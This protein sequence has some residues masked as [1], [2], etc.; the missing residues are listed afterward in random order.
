MSF[1]VVKVSCSND[2][3]DIFMAEMA[4]AG[5]DSFSDNDQ[6]FEA[7]IES[8]SFDEE[9]VKEIF[10]R[11]HT[12][13]TATY[14]V[15][16]VGKKNW[17]EEWEKNY[18]P[19]FIDDRCVVKASFHQIEKKFPYEITINP[20]MSFGTGHHETT[21]LMLSH[22]LEL[23]HEE[24]TVL[25]AGCGTGILA[26]MASKLGAMHVLA[27]DIDDWCVENSSENIELNHCENIDLALGDIEA[28]KIEG[29]FDI[30]LA[31]INK[32]VLLKE[33]PAYVSLLANGGNLLL[34]GFYQEDIADIEELCKENGLKL[35]KQNTRNRWAALVLE[36][37]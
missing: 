4:E 1:K 26:I 11:Y 18:D 8:S 28:L 12:M 17:N 9:V 34:S 29:T 16:E 19:I 32:N 22:Q 3:A 7:S 23:D 33:I 27:Y 2:F 30:I 15:E 37:D 31:N 36:K 10:N 25:D 14:V 35:L 20:K 13:T 24:K 21:H 6:G 5:F